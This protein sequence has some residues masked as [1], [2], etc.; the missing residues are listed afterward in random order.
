MN[1]AFGSCR[2]HVVIATAFSIGAL[3]AAR[4]FP[5]E[6]PELPAP[7]GEGEQAPFATVLKSLGAEA[8]AE[9]QQAQ[10]GLN[11]GE[12]TAETEARQSRIL[13][14]LQRLSEL[15]RKQSRRVPRPGPRHAAE[16]SLAVTRAGSG[17]GSADRGPRASASSGTASEAPEIDPPRRTAR[18]LATSVWGHLPARQRDRMQSRFSE[19][20]LPPYAELVRQY[21][22]ALATEGV[23]GQ[24]AGQTH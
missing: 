22:E 24:S 18:D 7:A 16:N 17:P 11:A 13:E 4:A 10:S 2:L 19:R 21:Y 3:C 20:F 8:I 15:A 5:D 9:M 23:E 1:R 14:R 12:L 6:R